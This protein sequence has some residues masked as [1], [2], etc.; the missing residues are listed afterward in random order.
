MPG[1]N[2]KQWTWQE[3]LV[4]ELKHDKKKAVLL[5]VLAVV[6]VV[7]VFQ[8]LASLTPSES[9]ASTGGASASSSG[10]SELARAASSGGSHRMTD[11]AHRRNEYLQTMDRT[12]DRDLFAPNSQ[13]FAPP[14]DSSS[15]ATSS[16]KTPEQLEQ[17]RW[18]AIRLQ[19]KGL[20]LRSTIVGNEPTA[21]INGMVLHKGDWV[22]GF[23]V[24]EIRPRSCTVRKDDVAVVLKME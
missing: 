24:T 21:V 9:Q 2:Q 8:Q 15:P 12:I 7:L 19:A 16:E 13:Y 22:A 3:R 5:G 18:Q 14:E 1:P 17:E 20:T 4:A 10:Q 6:A 23:E 11:S